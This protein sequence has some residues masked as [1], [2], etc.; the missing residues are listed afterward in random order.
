MPRSIRWR[1]IGSYTALTMLTVLLVGM[2]A[3]VLIREYAERQELDY[4]VAN[5]EAVASQAAPLLEPAPRVVAL[6]QLAHTAAFLG[7]AR[8]R[9]LDSGRRLLA[10]SGPPESHP[11]MAFFFPS[12]LGP[13][14]EEMLPG[15]VFAVPLMPGGGAMS[16]MGMSQRSGGEGTSALTIITVQ[17]APSVWGDR[18]TFDD[19]TQDR[20]RSKHMTTPEAKPPLLRFVYGD[21]ATNE[22]AR[23][24][25]TVTIS[26]T[27]GQDVLGYVELSNG[28]AFAL[29]SLRTVKRALFAAG[30]GVGLLA[31]VMGLVVSRSLTAPIQAL[32]HAAAQMGSGDLSARAAVKSDDEIGDLAQQFNHMAEGLQ[33]SFAELAAERDALRRFIAD[34][35]HELRTPITALKTFNELLRGPAAQDPEAQAEFLA[36]SAAQLDRLEWITA[37][38]LDLSRLDAHLVDLDLEP[39]GAADLLASVISPFRPLAHERN[40]HLV[41]NE[42]PPGLMLTCDR[43][44][45]EI[46]LRNLVDNAL[47][48]TPPGGRV[49]VGAERL[50][51]Q[52]HLWVQDT[53][54]GIPI[55]DLPHIFERFYRGRVRSAE[56][57][58]IPGSGLGLA[59]ARGIVEAHQGTLKVEN[60]E[61]GGA[62]FTVSIGIKE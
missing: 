1:L 6:R 27:E 10:D 31:V 21:S 60:A 39:T 44:R 58:E 46:A 43:G 57:K 32:A 38:L 3:L 42:P 45:L 25:R 35:S 37:N 28:P 56:G 12:R 14:M 23:S 48:F 4:L 53:G 18:L 49:A 34:A 17:R 36:E 5:A 22:T 7:N 29:E 19:P 13:R 24:D 40:I 52:V 33:A 47:K 16:A 50:D 59:I 9:I 30:I 20:G 8:V 55:D 26:I 54:P 51:G 61:G 2:L 15:G 62:R 41:V 11:Q